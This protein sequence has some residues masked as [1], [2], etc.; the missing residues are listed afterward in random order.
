MNPLVLNRRSSVLDGMTLMEVFPIQRL[1]ALLASNLLLLNWAEG[2]KEGYPNCPFSNELEQLKAY[3]K[4]YVAGLGIP[5]KYKKPKHQFGRSFPEKSLG[6]SSIRRTIRN[7]LI[8]DIYYDFDISNAQPAIMS[9][10]CDKIGLLCPQ[11]KEYVADRSRIKRELATEYQVSESL[12]KDLFIRLCF[13]G[14]FGGWCYDNHLQD[15]YP[16][17]FIVSFQREIADICTRA[18]AVNPVMYESA[19]QNCL[20]K[21]G[22]PNIL[23]SFF[24][25]FNQEYESRIVES[26]LCHLIHHTDLMNMEGTQ[27][28]VGAYEYDGIK[29]LKSNVDMY[30]GG[31]E[32]V[33]Q[34]LNEKSAEQGFPLTWV[35]KEI[36]EVQDLTQWLEQVEQSE[37][38]NESLLEDCKSIQDALDNADCGIVETLIKI[39]PNHFI[40]SV[41]KEDGS[42]GDWFGWNG[43]RWEKSDA[44]LRRAIMYDIE[45][46][47]KGRMAK[48]DEVYKDETYEDFNYKL[49][50]KT[51]EG[52]SS[53]IFFLKTAGTCQS[54]VS[55]AKSLLANYTL[56]FDTKEDLFGCENGVIDFEKE[57]FRPYHFDDHITWSCG[58]DFTPEIVFGEN[59]ENSFY[60]ELEDL[61]SQIFPDP[62]LRNYAFKVISTG[63]SGKAIEKFFVFNGNGRNGKGTTNELL[64]V[65]LGDYFASVSPTI[66]TEDQRKKTSSG[67][68]PEI[69][70]LDKKR[71]VVAKEPQ[72]DQP[73][74]NNIIKD[75]TGGGITQGRM[76]Y[77]SNTRVKLCMTMVLEANDKPPFSEAPKDADIER[78]NDI[79]FVSKFCATEEEWD[80]TTGKTNHIYPLNPSFKDAKWKR[81]HCNAMLNLMV[82]H[83][84]EV[85]AK[86]Y[87]V[88]AFKPDSVKQRSL[89]Y[90]QDSYDIHNIF[91]ALFEK[92]VEGTEYKN[93]KGVI[94]DEDWTLAKIAQQLR[95]SN[96]F[97]DLP[98]KR[99]KEYTAEAIED[100]LKKNSFYRGSVYKD[101]NAHS[102]KM[103]DYRLKPPP[104]DSEEEVEGI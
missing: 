17:A 100:F 44:P 103:K 60:Q 5:V 95:K 64:E 47:W 41:S 56:E 8:K 66:F 11:L 96:E 81:E 37:R 59:I 7:T 104:P 29:L 28:K 58:Y 4:K 97:M 31:V 65:V 63:L 13:G 18:K 92:R 77:S 32:G 75:L 22:T 61:F 38:P 26:I 67:A 6:L 42:K 27:T 51:K 3:K 101:T 9:C 80:S 93:W 46:D 72:K 62:E 24:G 88:D 70:K 84:L 40:Y 48:W 76:L 69:A 2:W 39:L 10:L 14:T 73:L 19:R 36:D 86:N 43:K 25:L 23:A 89:A 68:N 12:I 102:A 21:E 78:I 98:K 30:E 79:L 82:R 52:M 45:K 53:R 49:W 87:V 74:H 90:L 99:Q 55:V 16:N 35:C 57:C 71:Y 94:C 83:L 34:L 50:K 20:K 85:K 54:V 91:K 15:K 1:N 33:L